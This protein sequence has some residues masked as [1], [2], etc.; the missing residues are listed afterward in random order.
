LVYD[1]D[2]NKLGPEIKYEVDNR[3]KI[4]QPFDRIAYFLELEGADRNTQ[5]V[6]VSMDA[7]TDALDKIGVPTA[8][9]GA[10]FQQNLANMKYIR[11]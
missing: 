4:Q 10:R 1:L 3:S 5:F 9:S 6:Y 8:K 11:M 7:F 2:L